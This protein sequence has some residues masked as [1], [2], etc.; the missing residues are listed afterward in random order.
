MLNQIFEIVESRLQRKLRK[1]ESAFVREKT[2][3]KTENC[4]NA[5]RLLTG[6][7]R[8]C[9]LKCQGTN[10][11]TAIQ[12]W[13]EKALGCKLFKLANSSEVL[14]EKFKSFSREEISIRWPSVGELMFVVDQIKMI[15]QKN[16]E[17]KE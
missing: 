7:L 13:N 14:R 12:C 10:E 2:S 5:G 15:Q 4:G 8:A 6:Q 9:R 1:A 11:F 16:E 17:K 3:Q